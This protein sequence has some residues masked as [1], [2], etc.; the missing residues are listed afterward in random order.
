MSKTYKF[1]ITGAFNAGKTTF[2]NTLSDISAINTDKAI[3]NPIEKA[4]KASTTTALDYGQ[5]NLG[6]DLTVHLFGTPGQPRFDFMRHI[7]SKGMDGFIF[8]VDS[9]NQ[10]QLDRAGEL[11]SKFSQLGD[12]PLVV[13]ANKADL[14]GLSVD[15]LRTQLRLPAKQLIVSCVAMDREAAEHVIEVL[16]ALVEQG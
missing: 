2:V 11:L 12:T 7:L 8:L 15:E 6:Q 5:V 14:P 10:A 9:S 4:V 1:V 13:A 3:S 16:V